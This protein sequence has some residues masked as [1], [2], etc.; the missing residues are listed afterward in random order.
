MGGVPLPEGY[1]SVNPY[2]VADDAE[3]LINFLA[4]VFGAAEQG[5]TLRPDG[6]IDHGDVRIGDPW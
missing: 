3:R 1:H 4:K 5:R 6:R 2:I